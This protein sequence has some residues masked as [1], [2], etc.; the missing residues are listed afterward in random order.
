M[1]FRNLS[2]E[3]T[4]RVLN[5]FCQTEYWILYLARN[6]LIKYDL[7]ACMMTCEILNPAHPAVGAVGW[8]RD[9]PIVGT[10]ACAGDGDSIS[11]ATRRGH[12]G[13]FPVNKCK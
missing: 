13:S 4:I 1:V 3:S 6:S 11:K 8:W 5:C 10:A 7:M 2:S 12:V 9:A